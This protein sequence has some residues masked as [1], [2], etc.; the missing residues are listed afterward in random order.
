MTF[1]K[2]WLQQKISEMESRR[3]DPWLGLDEDD[4][5]TLAALKLALASIE[6]DPAIHRWRRVTVEPYGPYPWHY[7]DFIGFSQH[8]EG[9]EDE[10][11]YSAPP[12]PLSVPAFKKLAHELVE[13]L[14]DCDG[15]DHSAV[16]QYLKW[17][18]KTCRA[19]MLQGDK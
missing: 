4:S 10:Y 19:A 15:A 8:V 11:F 14:V 3:D 18:E 9:I 1:T 7:G 12:A 5:N 2:E 17:T 16:K 13:N 6:A